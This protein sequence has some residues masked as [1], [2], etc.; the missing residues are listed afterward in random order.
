MRYYRSKKLK[1]KVKLSC[2]YAFRCKG[3]KSPKFIFH[4]FLFYANSAGRDFNAKA[5]SE[6]KWY[7]TGMGAGPSEAQ[8]EQCDQPRV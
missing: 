1:V 3:T 6:L 5:E 2:F 7:L 8:I 4:D